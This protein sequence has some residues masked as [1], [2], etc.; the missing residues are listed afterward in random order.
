MAAI[1]G[2]VEE[3]RGEQAPAERFDPRQHGI[4]RTGNPNVKK[5]RKVR[6]PHE[7]QG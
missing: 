3:I 1:V 4:N 6:E 5:K 2:L 7:E